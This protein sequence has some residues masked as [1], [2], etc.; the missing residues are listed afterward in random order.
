VPEF[1]DVNSVVDDEL[2]ELCSAVLVVVF[3]EAFNS[4]EKYAGS[5]EVAD[6]KFG[7]E[8]PCDRAIS[9]DVYL[10]VGGVCG[11]FSIPRWLC[12]AFGTSIATMFSSTSERLFPVSMVD[13][14]SAS[15]FCFF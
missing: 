15:T 4:L 3:E 5:V 14:A 9:P 10:G 2:D 6:V 1:K 11:N 13:S 12:R 7:V 8:A